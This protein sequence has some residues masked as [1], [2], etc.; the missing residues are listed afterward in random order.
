MSPVQGQ[1]EID[2]DEDRYILWSV[3]MMKFNL[4]FEALKPMWIVILSPKHWASDVPPNEPWSKNNFNAMVNVTYFRS[5][6]TEA[7]YSQVI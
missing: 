2:F 3:L 6:L 5:L 1:E 7:K 4:Y